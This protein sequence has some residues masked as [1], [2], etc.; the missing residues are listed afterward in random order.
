MYDILPYSNRVNLVRAKASSLRT[1]QNITELFDETKEWEEEWAHSLFT[2]VM[3]YERDL[4]SRGKG[5]SVVNSH[6]PKKTK[7]SY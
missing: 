6:V 2:V 7:V 3:D 4:E 1:F 5:I